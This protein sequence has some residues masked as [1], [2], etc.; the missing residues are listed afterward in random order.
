VVRR[1]VYWRERHA[2]TPR[3]IEHRGPFQDLRI[4][5]LMAE[6]PEWMKRYGGR[7]KEILRGAESGLL[8]PEI[9]ARTDNGIFQELLDSGLT[10][11]ELPRVRLATASLSSLKGIDASRL[12][13]EVDD[14]LITKHRWGMPVLRAIFAGLW[15]GNQRVPRTTQVGRE[16]IY[17]RKEVIA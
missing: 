12:Q 11:H 13:S 5:Q 17:E 4:L 6:T 15:L 2:L 8:P 10:F 1:S 7:R 14:W 16:T 3:G 9:P